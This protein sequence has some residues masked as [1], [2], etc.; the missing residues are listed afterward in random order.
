MSCVS[1]DITI[2]TTSPSSPPWSKPIMSLLYCS[3]VWAFYSWHAL[4]SH[5]MLTPWPEC[6]LQNA[7]VIISH[8]HLLPLSTPSMHNHPKPHCT[9][10][11]S[12][13]PHP[14]LLQTLYTYHSICNALPSPSDHNSRYT[15][16]GKPVLTSQAGP[17][18]AG[19]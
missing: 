14:L 2:I 18:L 1:P 10:S 4:P 7:H 6:F 9:S 5:L 16:S 15:P 11:F 3:P 19:Y 17:I 13:P 8:P 12:F